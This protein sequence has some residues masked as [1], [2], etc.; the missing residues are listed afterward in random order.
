LRYWLDPHWPV[1][2]I[3]PGE[4]FGITVFV[5]VMVQGGKG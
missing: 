3:K 5:V 2:I 4:Y 1:R